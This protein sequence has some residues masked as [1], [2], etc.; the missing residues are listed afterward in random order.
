V[1]SPVSKARPGVPGR[2]EARYWDRVSRLRTARFQGLPVSSRNLPFMKQP[3]WNATQGCAKLSSCR[4][5]TDYLNIMSDDPRRSIIDALLANASFRYSPLLARVLRLLLEMHQKGSWLSSKELEA[6]V[7]GDLTSDDW[8]ARGRN[9]ISRLRRF[10]AQYFTEDPKGRASPF[11]VEIDSLQGH[12]YRLVFAPQSPPRSLLRVFLC[13]SSADKKQ[14]RQLHERLAKD[15]FAP[16][17]DEEDL[18]P[19]QNWDMEIKK[20]VRSSD[21]V[22]VC[23]SASSVTKQGFVQ[24]E[25]KTAL[26]AADEKPDGL[27]Y[28]IPLRLQECSVPERLKKWHWVDFFAQNGYAR[29]LQSLRIRANQA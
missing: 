19:G 7:F 27:V 9:A 21:V 23:L 20:A 28:I 2:I 15:G 10:L 25:I 5:A 6:G 14:V 29:L 24:K 11:R 17:L 16:W 1:H 4:L 3:A 12:G 26:D 13:H 22:L 8:G 18:L